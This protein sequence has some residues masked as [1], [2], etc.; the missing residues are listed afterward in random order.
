MSDIVSMTVHAIVRPELVL[1]DSP[2]IPVRHHGKGEVDIGV[3]R[4][5][6]LPSEKVPHRNTFV[7]YFFQ[8][9]P[10]VLAVEWVTLVVGFLPR[11]YWATGGY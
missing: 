1:S 3:G 10:R 8:P 11:Y 2:D 6:L 9:D 7:P 4:D 5:R